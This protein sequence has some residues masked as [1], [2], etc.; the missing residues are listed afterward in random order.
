MPL[1][2]EGEVLSEQARGCPLFLAHGTQDNVVRFEFG[3]M[4]QKLLAEKGADVTWK[5]YPMPHSACDEELQDLAAFLAK[6]LP[7]P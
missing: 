7:K 3:E 1:H 5:T 2:K 4:S 6:V